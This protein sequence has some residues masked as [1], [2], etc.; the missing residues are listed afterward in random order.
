MPVSIV[1]AFEMIDVDQQKRNRLTGARGA[2]DC[3]LVSIA[4]RALI[5][6]SRQRIVLGER[7]IKNFR[8]TKALG[9]IAGEV[10]GDGKNRA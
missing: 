3:P 1:D 2:I 6:E 5:E 8:A 7:L 10:S 4:K 9:A